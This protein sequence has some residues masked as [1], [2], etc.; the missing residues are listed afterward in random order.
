LIRVC[1]K[2]IAVSGAA[3]GG[4]NLSLRALCDTEEEAQT[5]LALLEHPNAPAAGG[6][7][8]CM[9]V[10]KARVEDN[11]DYEAARVRFEA[12]ARSIRSENDQLKRT[13]SNLRND[14]TSA[15][16]KNDPNH[17]GQKGRVAPVRFNG[18]SIEVPMFCV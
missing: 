9:S 3:W 15:Q 18:G 11:K 7:H 2:S 4:V 16:N 10:Q 14:V 12:V 8:T 6:C 13:I 1:E 5:A 17:A